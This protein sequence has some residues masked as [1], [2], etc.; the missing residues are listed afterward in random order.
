MDIAGLPFYCSTEEDW[1]KKIEEFIVLPEADK[2]EV[3][4][5]A[6]AYVDGYHSKEI[7]I[8]NWSK[9]FLSLYED[10]PEN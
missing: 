4:N 6:S 3:M 5:R 8:Q 9:I 1:S 10:I 7:I 2:K